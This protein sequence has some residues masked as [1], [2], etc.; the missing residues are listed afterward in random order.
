MALDRARLLAHIKEKADH[1]QLLVYAVLTGLA[2]AIE[3]GDFDE[4]E[5][6]KSAMVQGGRRLLVASEDPAAV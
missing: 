3:R 2:T 6:G 5:G 4:K 1:P